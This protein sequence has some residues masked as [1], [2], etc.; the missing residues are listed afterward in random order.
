MQPCQ[1]QFPEMRIFLSLSLLVFTLATAAAGRLDIAIVQ[2][3]DPKTPEQLNAALAG[4]SLFELT[5]SSRTMSRES[6][7]K[8][9]AVIFAQS[10]QTGG[11]AFGSST[12]LSNQRADVSGTLSGGSVSV[13]VEIIEGVKAG[14]RSF[15]NKVYTG[16]GSL[17]GGS[18][19]ILSMRI[20]KGKA[21][22]VVKGQAKVV[23][24]ELSTAVI[25]QYTP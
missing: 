13:K 9:G 10:I 20:I 14:L 4:S 2:F 23:T 8:G 21:P 5:N 12:R 17:A 15:E 6:D 1:K 16:S 18:P 3:P 19:Q 11:G 24:Y 25:A 22:S 7:L